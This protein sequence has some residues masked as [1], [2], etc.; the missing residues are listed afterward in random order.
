MED[1]Y[2]GREFFSH[3]ES[4][5]LEGLYALEQLDGVER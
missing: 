5:C 4:L 1:I 3:R 2:W